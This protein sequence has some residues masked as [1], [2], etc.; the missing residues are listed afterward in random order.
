MNNTE[1][2]NQTTAEISNC[3]RDRKTNGDHATTHLIAMG[4]ATPAGF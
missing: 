1:I 4:W 2:L 3:V